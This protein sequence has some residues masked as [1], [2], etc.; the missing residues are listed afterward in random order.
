MPSFRKQRHLLT[1]QQLLAHASY[2]LVKQ[3]PNDGYGQEGKRN[4]NVGKICVLPLVPLVGQLQPRSTCK[5]ICM[6]TNA[7]YGRVGSMSRRRLLSQSQGMADPDASSSVHCCSLACAQRRTQVKLHDEDIECVEDAH[8]KR[9]SGPEL[10]CRS[11]LRARAGKAHQASYG[12]WQSYITIE[13]GSKNP[14]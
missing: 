14:S 10:F 12:Q 5:R 11:R 13:C 7:G 3:P 1:Q 8:S 6:A 9:L 4:Y 2:L